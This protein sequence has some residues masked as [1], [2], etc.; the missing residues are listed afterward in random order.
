MPQILEYT[1]VKAGRY[2]GSLGGYTNTHM[3]S[4]IPFKACFAPHTQGIRGLH[5]AILFSPVTME[6]PVSRVWG[7]INGHLGVDILNARYWG[8]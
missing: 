7:V 5:A 8:K 6:E 2:M 1:E 3:V 4:A